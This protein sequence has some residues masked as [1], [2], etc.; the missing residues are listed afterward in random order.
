MKSQIIELA[1]DLIRRESISP[2]DAGCQQVIANRLAAQGFQIEWMPFGE[3]L[4]L[5]ATHGCD[6]EPCVVFAGHTDV[7]PVGDLQ[8]WQYPP[9]SAEI[10]DGMLYG[11]GEA[12]S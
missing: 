9:F 8:A 3:T 12:P 7:V 10:V 6:A 5:W 11:R 1:Q 2:E 4:N